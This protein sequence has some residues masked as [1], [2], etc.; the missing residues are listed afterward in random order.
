MANKYL[1]QLIW[2]KDK[3]SILFDFGMDYLIA[4]RGGTDTQRQL[5]KQIACGR[6]RVMDPYPTCSHPTGLACSINKTV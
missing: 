1:L 6:E 3:K 5:A 4:E 2:E